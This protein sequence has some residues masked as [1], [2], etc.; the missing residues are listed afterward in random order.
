MN[1]PDARRRTLSLA[2]FGLPRD[3]QHTHDNHHTPARRDAARA[4]P[5]IAAPPATADYRA[6]EQSVRDRTEALRQARLAR[7]NPGGKE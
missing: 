6:A 3:A 1:G 7:E 5:M 2:G 4:N